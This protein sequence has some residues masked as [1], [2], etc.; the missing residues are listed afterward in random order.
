[1]SGTVSQVVTLQAK[2]VALYSDAEAW[3]KPASGHRMAGVTEFV[4]SAAHASD[5][6]QRRP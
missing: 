1:M 5:E 3:R 2:D 4:T 6:E